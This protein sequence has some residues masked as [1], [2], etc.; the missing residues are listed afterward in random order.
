M[1]ENNKITDSEKQKILD[2]LNSVRAQCTDHSLGHIIAENHA[3]LIE[4][5][6]E[7]LIG[8]TAH[9]MEED[10]TG[11][12]VASKEICKKNYHIPVP[13]NKDYNQYMQGF[14]DFL[15]QCMKSSIEKTNES[16]KDKEEHNNE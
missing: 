7:I 13:S 11:T 3:K 6:H 9:V 1:T 12:T 8:V 10:D 4:C 14:F 15:E 16:V 2:T 5:R